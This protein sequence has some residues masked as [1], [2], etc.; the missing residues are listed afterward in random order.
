MALVNLARAAAAA[1]AD[2]ARAAAA[3]YADLTRNA[4]AA[5]TQMAMAA[6]MPKPKKTRAATAKTA[7]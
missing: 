6:R 3:A 1:P 2:F 5:T 7:S 4:A